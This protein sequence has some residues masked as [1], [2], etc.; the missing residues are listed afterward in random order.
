V[1][2]GE[3]TLSFNLP[4]TAQSA[5]RRNARPQD[6]IDAVRLDPLD[7]T[8]QVVIG[9]VTLLGSENEIVAKFPPSVFLPANPGPKLNVEDDTEL[10]PGHLFRQELHLAELRA[11]A[12]FLSGFSDTSGIA[13]GDRGEQPRRG[14]RRDAVGAPAVFGHR[15]PC[16]FRA[17]RAAAV[18]PLH[19][20]R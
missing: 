3:Q 7:R 14:H 8:A 15:A 6:A 19:V 16:D 2:K 11:D 18:E 4:D 10:L 1:S 9:A 20:L 17:R 12:A 5:F 13:A